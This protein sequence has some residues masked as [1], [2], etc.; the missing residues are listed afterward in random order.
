[1]EDARVHLTNQMHIENRAIVNA[2]EDFSVDLISN[3][4][5]ILTPDDLINSKMGL[6]KIKYDAFVLYAD[7]DV[8]FAKD[9]VDRME[10]NGFK[11]SVFIYF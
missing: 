8:S 10:E 7:E 3:K 5:E 11:V 4:F 1:M 6:P 9:L 2:N